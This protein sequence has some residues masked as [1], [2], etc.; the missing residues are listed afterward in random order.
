MPKNPALKINEDRQEV[1][2]GDKKVYLRPKE[3][4]ILT[5]LKKSNRTLSRVQLI[6]HIH[7]GDQSFYKDLRTIDQHISRIRKK[8][9][10]RF[11]ATVMT[12]GYRF[13]G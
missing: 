10:E 5:V 13:D 7:D 6:E 4:R 2:I 12:Y 3:Y 9:G 1:F 11:I 8:I